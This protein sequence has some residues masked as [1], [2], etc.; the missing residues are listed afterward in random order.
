MTKKTIPP[1]WRLILLCLILTVI[2]GG[3]SLLRSPMVS[4]WIEARLTTVLEARAGLSIKAERFYLNLFPVFVAA[5]GVSVSDQQGNELM[6]AHSLKAYLRV[7]SLFSATP[8][9]SRIVI[10]AP[11]ANLSRG[12]LATIA[13]GDASDDASDDASGTGVSSVDA[14]G[15]ASSWEGVIVVRD[16]SVSFPSNGGDEGL[17]ASGID[18]EAFIRKDIAVSLEV[19][20]LRYDIPGARWPVVQCSVRGRGGYAQKAVTIE[21]L[22]FTRGDTRLDIPG[23]IKSLGAPEMSGTLHPALSLD[24]RSLAGPF[25]LTHNTDGI[26]HAKGDVSFGVDPAATRLDIDMDGD[27]YLQTLLQAL[28]VSEHTISNL[29]GRIRARGKVSGPAADVQASAN[30]VITRSR[31]YGVDLEKGTAEVYYDSGRFDIKNGIARVYNGNAD[32]DVS[33]SILGNEPFSVDVAFNHA[34]SQPA[35]G[36]IH[37][38]NIGLPPGKVNGRISS[39]GMDFHPHGW[40]SFNALS[41]TSTPLGRVQSVTGTF[42]TRGGRLMLNGFELFTSRTHVGFNGYVGLADNDIGFNGYINSTDLSDMIA[43]FDYGFRA[44][45]LVEARVEGTTQDPVIHATADL[46]DASLMGYG[47]GSVSASLNY[48]RQRLDVTH[49]VAVSEDQ[50][51]SI[52]GHIAFPGAGHI[53]DFRN[54]EFSLSADAHGAS[55]S[56][57]APLLGD[58]IDISGAADIHLDLTGRGESP[59]VHGSAGLSKARAYGWYADHAELEYYYRNGEVGITNSLMQREESSLR[60]AGALRRGGGF[61]F[62]AS[63][64]QIQFSH[65]VNAPLLPDYRM[66]LEASGSGTLKNPRVQASAVLSQGRLGKRPI[67]GGRV[68]AMLNGTRVDATLDLLDGH[69]KADGSLDLNGAGKWNADIKLDYD[70]YDFILRR[71]MDFLPQDTILALEGNVRL[72]GDR[73]RFNADMHMV[74][75]NLSVYGQGF[76]NVEPVMSSYVDGLLMF[77]NIK[78]RGAHAYFELGGSM[79]MGK[80]MDI[81]IKG[82]A[83]LLP[84]ARYIDGVS[85]MRGTADFDLR[86]S[87][88]WEAPS[89]SGHMDLDDATLSLRSVPQRLTH[90]YG[91]IT[92]SEHLAVVESIVGR[93]GG[94]DVEATGVVEFKGLV[95]NDINI[96]ATASNVS[97]HLAPQFNAAL[98]GYLVLTGDGSAQTVNGEVLIN[99]ATYKERVEWK[100]WLFKEKSLSPA[101]ESEWKSN[102]GLNVRVY[103]TDEIKVVNNL[104]DAPIRGDVFVRGSL[105]AP[106]LVGRIE[107]VG[108]KVFFRNSELRIVAATADF[109]DLEG[110]LPVVSM[111]AEASIKGYDIWLD[112]SGRADSMDLTLNSDPPLDQNEIVALLTYGD[113]GSSVGGLEA[114]LGAAEATFILTGEIQDLMEERLGFFTGLDR[115]QIDPYVSRSTGTV[116][117]R[118]TVAKKLLGEKLYVTY[119]S[120]LDATSEQELK[121]EYVLSENV[122]VMGGQDY[123]GSLGGDLKFRFRFE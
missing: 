104:A 19:Q 9:V 26:I 34:D 54:P 20:D 79:D 63:S 106:V 84:M 51:H 103:G 94:G 8:Q 69:I 62:N 4:G 41:V 66:R 91:K 64:D 101:G 120:T 28:G 17:V 110:G 44:G 50:R 56:S 61:V 99:N 89:L 48:S 122:S 75:A 92:F 15:R 55:L 100:R 114:G 43:P 23:S 32:V 111:T 29:H 24:M 117:P 30:A 12:W 78:M 25:R 67:G 35:L 118:L 73:K 116:T 81:T 16:G 108:G 71:V 97:A 45:G 85:L 102:V 37:I 60:L 14:Q 33:F 112:M 49:L 38:G 87:G 10:E 107:A 109:A 119:A 98:E 72:W 80:A 77:G 22:V 1:R 68:E 59:Q 46:S 83:S 121:L 123:T 21:E 88:P 82:D 58:G 65:I 47:L 11:V 70:R 105:A 31:L 90:I 7:A 18:L 95:I 3:Y 52:S 27:F 5:E 96:E 13:S 39:S 76:A 57:L 74:K 2:V 86:A 113:L 115:I 53:F 40:A 42:E 93:F 36:R 6:G